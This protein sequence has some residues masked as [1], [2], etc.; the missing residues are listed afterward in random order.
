MTLSHR[1]IRAIVRK[2]LRDY[3]RNGSIVAGMAII[4]MIFLVQP[5]VSVFAVASSAAGELRHRHELLYM[6]G[7]PALVPSALA[8][9]AVV[10]ERQ[11][12]TLEPVLTTPI[13]REE[14][15]LGKAVAVLAPSVLIAYAVYGVFLTLVGLFAKPGVSSALIRGPDV[16]AQVLFT[17]LLAGWSIWIGIAISARAS[18]VRVAQQ[19]A[20]LSSLPMI[21]VT[22]LLAL[23]TIHPTP[24]IALILGVVLLLGNRLGWR[25]GSAAFDRERL[26]TGSRAR[27][28]QRDPAR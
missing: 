24:R 13:R 12:G 22:T 9:Y 18:D 21:A 15:L 25:L 7:I 23:N 17:P 28:R 1:R 3:R 19:I 4:P 6:L 20:V 26:I 27:G 8:A 10:G 2:E 11:Q 16:V 5:L 14:L